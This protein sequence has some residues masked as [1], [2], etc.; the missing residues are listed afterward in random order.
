MMIVT[1]DAKQELRRRLVAQTND[2]EIGIRLRLKLPRRFRLVL[3]RESDGDQVIEY[4][5]S[6]VLLIGRDS[7]GLV[8]GWT[9]GVRHTAGGA[10]LVLSMDQDA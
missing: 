3:D 8:A 6:K 4:K 9:I 2:P 7:A 5:G 1:E 10:K